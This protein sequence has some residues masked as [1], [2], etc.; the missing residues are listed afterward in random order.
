MKITQTYTPEQQQRIAEL[1]AMTPT[2]WESICKG[3]G[4]CCL[5]KVDLGFGPTV[6]MDLCC[7]HLNCENQRCDIYDR[8]LKVRASRCKKVDMD[9]VLDGTLLP[10]SCGY[11]E[12]IFGPSKYQ[13]TVDW[14]K[15]RPITDKEWMKFNATRAAQHAIVDSLAWNFR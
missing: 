5:R 8:R 6:Y 14:T 9:V 1:R 12:Y 15:V 4:V 7:P 11:R 2:Q 10:S 13:A 3:C